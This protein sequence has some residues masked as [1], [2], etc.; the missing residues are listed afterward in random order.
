MESA[1]FTQLLLSG[2]LVFSWVLHYIERRSW[3]DRNMAR[4]LP[5]LVMAENERKSWFPRIPD[6]PAPQQGVEI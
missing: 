1:Q 4:D 2:L 6:R 5:E 3:M